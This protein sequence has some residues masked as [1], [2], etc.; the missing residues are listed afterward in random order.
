M[1]KDSDYVIDTAKLSDRQ[2]TVLQKIL[3]QPYPVTFPI[4]AHLVSK[5]K[6]GTLSL[7]DLAIG[8]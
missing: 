2:L 8:R 3:E 6:R 7:S 4:I 5:A 1:D